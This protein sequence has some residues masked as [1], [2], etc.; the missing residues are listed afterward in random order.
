MLDPTC[1]ILLD[2]SAQDR[3]GLEGAMDISIGLGEVQGEMWEGMGCIPPYTPG[4]LTSIQDLLS[5]AHLEPLAEKE[6]DVL[7]E[8]NR[9]VPCLQWHSDLEGHLSYLHISL[10][11][12]LYWLKSLSSR[13]YL[14]GLPGLPGLPGKAPASDTR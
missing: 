5:E 12:V 6:L 4:D 10:P 7:Q 3:E 9:R 1:E 8:T 13:A 14:A 11:Q 2:A